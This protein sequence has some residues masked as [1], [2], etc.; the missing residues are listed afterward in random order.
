MGWG[1]CPQETL[2]VV[3]VEGRYQHLVD[4]GW[5]GCH[6]SRKAQNRLPATKNGLASRV[7]SAG[8]RNPG[9]NPSHPLLG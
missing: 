7:N 4:R 6:A 2:I 8:V 5:A 3:T 9:L 1:V